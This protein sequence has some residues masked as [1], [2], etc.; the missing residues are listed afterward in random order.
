MTWNDLKQYYFINRDQVY[1]NRVL[2]F[3]PVNNFVQNYGEM[4]DVDLTHLSKAKCW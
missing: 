3:F 2:A 4:A 1:C